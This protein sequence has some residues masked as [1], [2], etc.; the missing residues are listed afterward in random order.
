MPSPMN[1]RTF[2]ASASLAAVAPALAT[3]P[4][5]R[6]GACLTLSG[7]IV[8]ANRGPHDR[9]I[10]QLMTKHGTTFDRAFEFDAAMLERL[11]SVAIAPTLEYDA[12]PHRLS[13][14]LLS[15]VVESAGLAP[16]ASGT[17]ALRGIDGYTVGVSLADARDWRMIVAT[18]VDG[19][20]MGLG[21]LGPLWAVYDA[22]RLPAFKDRPLNERFALC[23]WG[24]YAVEV[25]VV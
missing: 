23:P 20:P 19:R 11:P 18:H 7:A 6:G 4:I 21:G 9:A 3:S 8:S 12:R 13:G 24:L 25:R 15:A 16:N 14:P 10:D 5:P 22:D 2:L 1:K 17:L